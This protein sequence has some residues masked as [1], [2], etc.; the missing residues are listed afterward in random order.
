M[1]EENSDVIKVKSLELQIRKYFKGIN[2]PLQQLTWL[3]PNMTLLA[4]NSK[5][6]YFC[7]STGFFVMLYIP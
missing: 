7:L 2:N 1:V 3:S 5:D 6:S 4:C